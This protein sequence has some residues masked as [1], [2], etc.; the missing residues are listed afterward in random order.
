MTRRHTTLALALAGAGALVATPAVAIEI[1]VT[2]AMLNG[3]SILNFD[4][5]ANTDGAA[6]T[7]DG[8]TSFFAGGPA[9]PPLGIGSL[10]QKVGPDG[11]DATR[12]LTSQFN[13]LALSAITALSYSTYVSQNLGGQAT[14]LQFRID[15]D[16]DGAQ[17]DRLFFEPV[18][19][20]GTYS[21]VG[22]S[23]DVIPNQCGMVA[24]CV[25][26]GGWQTWNALVGGWWSDLDSAGGPPLTTLDDYFTQYPGAKLIT[27]GPAIRIQAGGGAGAW[28]DFMGAVDSFTIATAAET[29]TFNFESAPEPGTLAVFGLGLLGLG[30]LRRR[31]GRVPEVMTA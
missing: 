7:P 24:L 22:Y 15:R 11:N 1:V 23:T 20:N 10:H 14:Y 17:D 12:A 2:P 31:K 29:N 18:Y 30:A 26:L 25:T 4:S 9:T 27:T 19:Q 8:T 28:D 5:S 3:W 13:G 6:P 21:Q 16:G